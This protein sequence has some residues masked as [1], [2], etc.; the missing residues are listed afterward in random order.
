[1]TK[2]T[3]M[4]FKKTKKKKKKKKKKVLVDRAK[5]CGT[6]EPQDL[7]KNPAD[8][9]VISYHKY[10]EKQLPLAIYFCVSILLL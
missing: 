1:M 6:L 8:I 3:R 4:N 2:G 5:G 7:L 9:F 10:P